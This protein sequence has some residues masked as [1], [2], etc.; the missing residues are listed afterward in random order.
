MTALTLIR[1]RKR[2]S[3]WT[4]G[5]GDIYDKLLCNQAPFCSLLAFQPFLPEVMGRLPEQLKRANV[6]PI[7]LSDTDLSF[8]LLD[9][10]VSV[11]PGADSHNLPHYN[12]M[13][14]SRLRIRVT[15]TFNCP[16]LSL[17]FVL[18]WCNPA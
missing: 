1:T 15:S 17:A 9:L 18:T 16:Q 4:L 8:F 14:Q 3:P 12:L 2:L 13:Q 5:S 6:R 11:L 10:L 7:L